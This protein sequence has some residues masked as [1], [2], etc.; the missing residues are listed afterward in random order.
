MLADPRKLENAVRT[1]MLPP[2]TNREN[3]FLILRKILCTPKKLQICTLDSFFFHIIE[4][5]PLECGIAGEITMLSETDDE[6]RVDAL[7]RLIRDSEPKQ[8]SVLLELI[9]QVS[10]NAEPFSIF[11]PA[12]KLVENFYAEFLKY[13]RETLWDNASFLEPEISDSDILKDEELFAMR[14]ILE[15]AAEQASGRVADYLNKLAGLA[16]FAVQYTRTPVDLDADSVIG[17]LC[18]NDPEWLNAPV[19]KMKYYK[20]IITLEGPVLEALKRIVRHLTAVEYRSITNRTRAVFELLNKFDGRYAQSV[21]RNGNLTFK[22]IVY[23]LKTDS[24]AN[25]FTDRLILEERLDSRY[26]H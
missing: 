1:G 10:L 4:A 17:K 6:L 8:R 19:L 12:K 9:K 13:P 25:P 2:E 23:L 26:N 18:T 14:G 11:E 15:K 24:D 3:L 21:R 20:S 22:D 5:F 16:E 7:L